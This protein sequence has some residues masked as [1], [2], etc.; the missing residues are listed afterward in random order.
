MRKEKKYCLPKGCW[1]NCLLAF[2]QCLWNGNGQLFDLLFSGHFCTKSNCSSFPA[3]ITYG[4]KQNLHFLLPLPSSYNKHFF[5]QYLHTEHHDWK[6]KRNALRH[7]YLKISVTCLSSGLL[8]SRAFKMYWN[9]KRPKNRWMEGGDAQVLSLLL[10][11]GERGERTSHYC[12][13]KDKE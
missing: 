5:S 10:L 4:H 9:V 12:E 7:F 8:S 3:A 6:K 1:V 2:W 11:K 13:W